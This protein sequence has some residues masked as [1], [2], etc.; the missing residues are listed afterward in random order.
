MIWQA[1]IAYL[2]SSATLVINALYK[3]YKELWCLNPNNY[4][5][6]TEASAFSLHCLAELA[7]VDEFELKI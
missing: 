4:K 2:L 7:G 1:L 6:L 3:I 5:H